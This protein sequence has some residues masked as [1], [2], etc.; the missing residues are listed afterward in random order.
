LLREFQKKHF[1][2]FKPFFDKIS[3][4]AKKLKMILRGEFFFLEVG[5]LFWGI[6]RINRSI[7]QIFGHKTRFLRKNFFKYNKYFRRIAFANA[8]IHESLS[9]VDKRE[10]E[11]D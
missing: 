7:F 11:R 9:M 3:F 1:S 6:S 8:K 4:C 2:I 5:N 10:M